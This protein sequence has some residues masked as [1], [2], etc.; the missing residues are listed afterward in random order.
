MHGTQSG[1]SA[2]F[3]RIHLMQSDSVASIKTSASSRQSN[4]ECSS[5]ATDA[6]L[7]DGR[8]VETVRSPPSAQPQIIMAAAVATPPQPIDRSLRACEFWI[9]P[10]SLD[11]F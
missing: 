8:T 6:G 1:Q 3:Y 4:N 5:L 10:S 9:D 7:R 11:A 2:V